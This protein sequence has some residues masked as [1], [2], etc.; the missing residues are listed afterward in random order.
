M[1]FLKRDTTYVCIGR[2][3][4][5]DQLPRANALGN[6]IQ[7]YCY[8]IFISS[9][10]SVLGH[11]YDQQRGT[12]LTTPQLKGQIPHYNSNT[13]YMQYLCQLLIACVQLSINRVQ[14]VTTRGL[15]VA[16]EGG[17]LCSWYLSLFITQPK[18]FIPTFNCTCTAGFKRLPLEAYLCVFRRGIFLAHTLLVHCIYSWYLSRLF[19]KEEKRPY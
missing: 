3:V 19:D 5:P 4:D 9:Y 10:Y 11:Q 8:S 2:D 6:Y 14:K 1:A 17:L 7:R 18:V 12:S 15:S 16:G 13:R